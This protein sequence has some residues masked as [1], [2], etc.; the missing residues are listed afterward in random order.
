MSTGNARNQDPVTAAELMAELENDPEYTAEARREEE[1]RQTQISE[2]R[3]LEA[4]LVK[5]LRNAGFDVQ[6]AWDL[7]N[8]SAPYREALPVLLEHLARSYPDRVREG[9]ARALAVAEARFGWET[10]LGLY[11]EEPANTDAKDGL[12]VA[13]AAVA[14]DA[15]VSEVVSLARDQKHGDSRVLLLRALRR[16][17]TDEAREALES[18]A[19]DPC[20][21]EQAR[22]LLSGAE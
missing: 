21:G 16:A 14:G 3:R 7:V 9:I 2:W 17:G 1:A 10:L 18:L 4:P 13:V 19:T 20:L 5:D 8:T 22:R 15:D 6:S 11:R 12:A